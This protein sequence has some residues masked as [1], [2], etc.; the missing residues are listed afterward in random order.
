MRFWLFFL[1]S[2]CA[3]SS[4][5][6]AIITANTVKHVILAADP[7]VAPVYTAIA[8][9]KLAASNGDLSAYKEQM[10]AAD[11][12]VAAMAVAKNAAQIYWV[13]VSQ[14][15]AAA[16]GGGLTKGAA[17]CLEGAITDLAHAIVSAPGGTPFYGALIVLAGELHAQA[18][19]ASCVVPEAPQPPATPTPTPTPV[20]EVH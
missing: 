15:Q 19:G 18:A 11:A 5:D 13:A 12:L 6:S 8:S 2:G 3:T 1:L 17:A 14:W 7:I 16:D 9:D 20:T 4:L 10:A